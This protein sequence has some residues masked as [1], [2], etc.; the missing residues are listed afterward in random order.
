MVLLDSKKS[1]LILCLVLVVSF[2]AI[3]SADDLADGYSLDANGN[4]VTDEEARALDAERVDVPSDLEDGYSLDAN[5]NIVTD[6]EARAL[7]AKRE[8]GLNKNNIVW[9]IVLIIVAVIVIVFLVWVFVK[10]LNSSDDYP[11]RNV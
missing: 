11:S 9:I 6:E 2:V 4:I 10:K 3:V 1:V 8:A 5:G 7:D